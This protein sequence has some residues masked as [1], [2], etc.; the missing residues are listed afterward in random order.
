MGQLLENHNDLLEAILAVEGRYLL[1]AKTQ[2]M[3]ESMLEDLARALADRLQDQTLIHM[4]MRPYPRLFLGYTTEVLAISG[5][6]IE[7]IVRGRMFEGMLL[8]DADESLRA[9][10]LPNLLPQETS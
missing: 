1:V 7:P 6:R 8:L 5:G 2:V 4:Q 9:R 3:A 10:L